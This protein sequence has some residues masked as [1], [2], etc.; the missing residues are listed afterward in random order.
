MTALQYPRLS[1]T[2]LPSE[3]AYYVNEISIL[4]FSAK[5]SQWLLIIQFPEILSS[6]F[7]AAKYLASPSNDLIGNLCSLQLRM[8]SN[9]MNPCKMRLNDGDDGNEHAKKP[10]CK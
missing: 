9:S 8:M 6:G 7:S 5:D 1:K 3:L 4:G 2:S 10:D